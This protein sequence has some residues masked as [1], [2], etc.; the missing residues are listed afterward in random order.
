MKKRF[1]GK[2]RVVDETGR[3]E[4]IRVVQDQAKKQEKLREAFH[5][6]WQALYAQCADPGSRARLDRLREQFERQKRGVSEPAQVEVETAMMMKQAG[7]TVAFL[8]ESETRTADLE[9]YLG[10]DR[11][12]VEITAI[13]PNPSMRRMGET[14]SHL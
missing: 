1:R 7:F 11:L 14:C 6:Q 12:F 5:V 13:V 9:C 2:A 8:E 3:N 4:Y 10:I